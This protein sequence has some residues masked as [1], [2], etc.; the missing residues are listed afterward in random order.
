MRGE[1]VMAVS[2][3]SSIWGSARQLPRTTTRLRGSE[4]FVLVPIRGQT[5]GASARNR[6]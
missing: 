2:S 4:G 1:A 6:R 5:P 3:A